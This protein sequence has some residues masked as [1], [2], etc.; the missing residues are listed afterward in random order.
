MSLLSLHLSYSLFLLLC[1]HITA[2]VGPRDVLRP[3]HRLAALL[4]PTRLPSARGV[5]QHLWDERPQLG[6]Q[7]KRVEN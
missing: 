3:P 2:Y 1:A 4:T 7:E 6:L 5:L